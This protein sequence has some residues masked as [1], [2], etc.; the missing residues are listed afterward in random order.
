MPVSLLFFP[1]LDG[2]ARSED[3]IVLPANEKGKGKMEIGS[4]L[5]DWAASNRA[6]R[7]ST[8]WRIVLLGQFVPWLQGSFGPITSGYS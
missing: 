7:T 6:L 4:D 8:V 5:L 1:S 3:L 2:M